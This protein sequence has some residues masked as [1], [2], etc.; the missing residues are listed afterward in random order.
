M[1][2]SRASLFLTCISWHFALCEHWSFSKNN[3]P[4]ICLNIN[5]D[6]LLKPNS[7]KECLMLKFWLFMNFKR[8]RLLKTIKNANVR[9][10]EVGVKRKL[11]SSVTT[12]SFHMFPT[13]SWK[14]QLPALGDQGE[15]SQNMPV[16][17]KRTTPSRRMAPHLWIADTWLLNAHK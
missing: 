4:N 15:S 6:L 12:N 7:I 17:N 9:H 10:L 16:G 11:A 2:V 5:C 13:C 8:N 14:R 3:Q 1:L